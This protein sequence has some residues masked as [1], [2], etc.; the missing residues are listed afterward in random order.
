MVG[1]QRR[2]A[3]RIRATRAEPTP[4]RRG[5]GVQLDVGPEGELVVR[6]EARRRAPRS[7]GQLRAGELASG[8]RR[9]RDDE[10][11]EPRLE[12]PERPERRASGPGQRGLVNSIDGNRFGGML[13]EP[14]AG[15]RRRTSCWRDAG[16]VAGAVTRERDAHVAAGGANLDGVA[17][18]RRRPAPTAR[19]R[20]FCSSDATSVLGHDAQAG[21]R[22]AAARASKRTRPR[23]AGSTPRR[24]R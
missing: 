20:A 9:R 4:R 15:S 16:D 23:R 5:V 17:R 21:G 7:T 6:R 10:K 12:R 2:T 19:K 13:S 22:S 24:R 3:A 8:A 14:G 11:R 18:E 1:R